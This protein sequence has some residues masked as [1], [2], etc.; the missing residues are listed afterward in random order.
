MQYVISTFQ[1]T[2]SGSQYH[3]KGR[4]LGHG[5]SSILETNERQRQQRH[6]DGL[7]GALD[8]RR[9]CPLRLR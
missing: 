8:R 6:L 2:L 7:R 3:H 1:V 9:A 4:A 5:V